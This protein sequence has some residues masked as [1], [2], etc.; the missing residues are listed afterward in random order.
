MNILPNYINVPQNQNEVQE[1]IEGVKSRAGFPQVVAAVDGCHV[2][3]IGPR[4]SP[5]DYVYRKGFP[6]LILQ[7]LVDCNYLF[8]E[9]C[10]GW[11][12]T[13]RTRLQELSIVYLVLCQSFSSARHVGDDIWCTSSSPDIR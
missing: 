6:S 11:P 2:P 10:V 9:I 4:Q 1:K 13:R 8:L 3:I 12:S 7:E 5:E